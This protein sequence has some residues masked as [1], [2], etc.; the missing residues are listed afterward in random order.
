MVNLHSL[1]EYIQRDRI[2]LDVLY[3]IQRPKTKN[4]PLRNEYTHSM[5]ILFI[6]I[7]S[8]TFRPFFARKAKLFTRRN[9]IQ[10]FSQ[11]I[12]NVSC[13]CNF[14]IIVRLQLLWVPIDFYRY[15]LVYQRIEIVRCRRVEECFLPLF[16][17]NLYEAHFYGI[18]TY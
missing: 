11:F 8:I 18:V 2:R 15:T 9:I 10:I 6:P 7:F 1:T 16:H 5:P 3:C 14:E 17:L 13:L 4:W 12:T